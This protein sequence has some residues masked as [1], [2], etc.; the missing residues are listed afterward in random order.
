MR[1]NISAYTEPGVSSPAYL[2]INREENGEYSISVR[3]AGQQ[4][5]ATIMLS[6]SPPI[7]ILNFIMDRAGNKPRGARDR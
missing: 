2:S 4:S 1:T 5:P 6:A 7:C 3:E